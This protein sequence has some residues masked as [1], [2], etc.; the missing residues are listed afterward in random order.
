MMKKLALLFL[1]LLFA[2]Q[3]AVAQSY[4]GG[5]AVARVWVDNPTA[6]GITDTLPAD[7]IEP[8]EASESGYTESDYIV[9]TDGTSNYL[10]EI[11]RERKFRT[12]CEP[13]KAFFY[14]P[15]LYYN[16]PGPV[17]HPHQASGTITISPSATYTSQRAAPSS[18]CIGALL[19]NVFYWEP[20]M[21]MQLTNG[22]TVGVH[23]T[24]DVFY[25]INGDQGQ[26]Q[27][28]TWLRRNFAFIFGAN[29][30]DYNDQARRDEI[31]AAG[32]EYPGSPETPAGFRGWSCQLANGDYVTVTR[33]ASRMK[34][35]AGVELP[36]ASRHLLAPDGSDP[37]GGNCIGTV[38]NPGFM[39][40][41]LIAQDCW[42]GTNNRAPDGRGHVAHTVRKSDNTII[43]LC[44]QPYVH[45][46]FLQAKKVFRHAGFADYGKWYYGSDRMNP[47]DTPAD[48]TSLDPC[49]A[50]GPWFCNGSTGHAD[51]IYGWNSDIA[52]EWQRECLG[53]PVRGVS[54]VNGPAECDSSQI[55][56]FRRLLTGPSPDP[57]KSGNCPIIGSCVDATPGSL[58][59]Y[60]PLSDDVQATVSGSHNHEGAANDNEPLEEL[61]A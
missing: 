53:I 61:A 25:Y 26:T 14:D 12:V 11:G 8:S 37:W 29:P 9:T 34:S 51:W 60:E 4:D 46:P 28:A 20:Q 15:I 10:V 40:I 27:R 3:M 31:S 17:G 54:P 24:Q 41:D 49:R 42:D 48:P 1:A 38:A 59:R 16:N 19:N 30:M 21:F 55:S 33:T 50:T 52:D 43:N 5:G 35:P 57:S 23:H 47:P 44:P 45:I 13:S 18:N 7:S 22:L 58:D 2:P 32:Y 6:P 56:K 36:T 39:T